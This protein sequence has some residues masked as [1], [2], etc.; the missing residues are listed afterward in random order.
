MDVAISKLSESNSIFA[1]GG[2]KVNI[3]DD[4]LTL[5]INV[6]DKP[7][8]L[9]RATMNDILTIEHSYNKLNARNTKKDLAHLN[10]HIMHLFRLYLTCIEILE[11]QVIH[12]YRGQ[13]RA[14]N[15]RWLVY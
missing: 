13:D 1:E 4:K 10:K 5:D 11:K 3:R 6:K 2:L 8:D 7:I 12:T 15:K 9:V 14:T